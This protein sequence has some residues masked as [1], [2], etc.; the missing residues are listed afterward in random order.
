MTESDVSVSFENPSPDTGVLTFSPGR[1]VT[2]FNVDFARV[3][4]VAGGASGGD[5][6]EYVTKDETPV[7]IVLRVRSQVVPPH[8]GDVSVR[9]DD[10]VIVLAA[11]DG[12]TQ[13]RRAL[14]ISWS[15]ADRK[16]GKEPALFLD[17]DAF[18]L[19]ERLREPIGQE[20]L[21]AGSRRRVGPSG[22]HE[23]ASRED[24]TGTA[25][26]GE[27]GEEAEFAAIAAEL[28]F[29][30]LRVG[31]LRGFATDESLT[32]AQPNGQPGSGLTIVVGANNA[33]KSTVWE[34]FDGI[35]RAL[36]TPVS[37]SEGRRNRAYG[38]AVNIELASSDGSAFRLAS[39][40]PGTSETVL[41][42]VLA[43]HDQGPR[44]LVVVPSR[45]QFQAYFGRNVNLDRNWMSSAQEYSRNQQR[46]MFTGRL[47]GLH[48]DRSS[49]EV[50]NSLLREVVGYAVDWRIDQSDQGQYFL[51]FQ[52]TDGISH[53]SDGLGDGMTSLL[54]ILDSLY[55]SSSKSLIVID[56]PELS[57]HPQYL[58]RLLGLIGR[59][60]SNRQIVIFTHSPALVSWSFVANGAEIAR[61]YKESGRSLIAQPA[62]EVLLDL[63]KSAEGNVNNP[64]VLGLDANETLFLED[65]V[66]LLE[67]QEDVVYLPRAASSI[68][69]PIPAPLFG[70]GAGGAQ[71]IRAVMKLLETLRYRSV[72]ALLDNNVPETASALRAEFPSYRVVEVPAEDIRTKSATRAKPAKRG[73]LDDHNTAV[74]P[75]LADDF[76]NVL[77]ELSRYFE[78]PTT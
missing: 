73:L 2:R 30:R 31:G 5:L 41:K 75:E 23:D 8:A 44:D 22:A 9:P 62:R 20:A 40:A 60:S 25:E 34:A 74:R 46:D 65:R 18:A 4:L 36:R 42:P 32:L 66:I 59:Y 19:W 72:A 11:W 55:D 1:V 29:T 47:F 64:H 13:G 12:S 56:E 27:A 77:H 71:N 68:D 50:F 53:T 3:N 49:L 54:F 45:R 70:W 78:S 16:A 63:L 35:A 69:E 10:E 17:G 67:G 15:P 51:K 43:G 38:D 52:G 6:L 24:A 58:K 33:G 39:T 28:R 57:L 26:E 7:S 37:F 21:G 14:A 76:R 61:V 48:Q